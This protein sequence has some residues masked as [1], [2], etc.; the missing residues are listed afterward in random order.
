MAREHRRLTGLAPI[1]MGS[2]IA[3]A[4][5]LSPLLLAV[6]SQFWHIDWPYLSEVGQAY[7]FASAMFS[8][9]ALLAVSLSVIAQARSNH[10][11][12]VQAFHT[13]QSSLVQ[14]GLSD[15]AVYMPCYGASG[16][17]DIK[18]SQQSL[19]CTLRANYWLAAFEQGELD[20]PLLRAEF[21][22]EIYGNPVSRQWWETAR[23]HW[24]FPTA[25]AHRKRMA[26]IL[27]EEFSKHVPEDGMA[28]DFIRRA[29]LGPA[30]EDGQP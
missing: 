23:P 27:D 16:P 12:R 20:E 18:R 15:P 19:F 10:M 28:T 2:A 26:E 5:I 1:A 4:A 24:N 13:M 8:A 7:G 30:E 11:A 21:A 22:P 6:I 14:I 9:L 17:E 29:N 3:I 25:P